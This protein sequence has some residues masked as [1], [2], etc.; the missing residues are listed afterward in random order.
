MKIIIVF[1]IP[2]MYRNVDLVCREPK[3]GSKLLVAGTVTL[4]MVFAYLPARKYLFLMESAFHQY[5]LTKH[6][7]SYLIL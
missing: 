3:S 7:L 2:Y 6:R 5:S 4:S 1:I